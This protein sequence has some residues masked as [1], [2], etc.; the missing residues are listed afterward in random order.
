[1]EWSAFNFALNI[2]SLWGLWFICLEVSAL[3]K[4]IDKCF[5]VMFPTTAETETASLNT[6]HL[7]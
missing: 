4:R 5:D 7:S 6:S 2:L 1:M 3:H